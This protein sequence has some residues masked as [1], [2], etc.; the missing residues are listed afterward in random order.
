MPTCFSVQKIHVGKH[1][2][3]FSR[4]EFGVWKRNTEPDGKLIGKLSQPAFPRWSPLYC[5]FVACELGT[6]VF[7]NALPAR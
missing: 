3:A 7:F 6:C 2:D 4:S 1:V 5:F